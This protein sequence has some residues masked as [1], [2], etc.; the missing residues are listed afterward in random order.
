MYQKFSGIAEIKTEISRYIF[1]QMSQWFYKRNLD[2]RA[3][4]HFQLKNTNHNKQLHFV[5]PVENDSHWLYVNKDSFNYAKGLN[6]G[7]TVYSSLISVK[8]YLDHDPTY[9]YK[10]PIIHITYDYIKALTDNEILTR[11]KTKPIVENKQAMNNRIKTDLLNK[12]LDMLDF[13][14]ITKKKTPKE[15]DFYSDKNCYYGCDEFIQE[16]TDEFLYDKK[17]LNCTE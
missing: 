7:I 15:L 17:Y 1:K 16:Y 8:I 14:V 12:V 10:Q 6:V 11:I 13:L 9:T 2:M 5:F 4:A 3:S